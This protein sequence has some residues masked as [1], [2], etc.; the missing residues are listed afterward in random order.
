MKVTRIG[1]K[2]KGIR[3]LDKIRTRMFDKEHRVVSVTLTDILNE[4][5]NGNTF[6]WA[7]LYLEATG[8]LGKGKSIFDFEEQI[9]K[10]ENGL[11]MS[12]NELY[13]L[14][15]RF[16]QIKDIIVT[17]CKDEKLLCRY[18]NDQDMYERCDIVINMFDACYW[19]IFSKMKILFTKL[20]KN[21]KK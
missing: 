11:N 8:N 9:N 15:T 1:M 2:T 21:L 10:S 20:L 7:I 17:G 12:W 4:I 3:I 19:E 18:E 16:Y 5:K 14:A 6:Y 13:L